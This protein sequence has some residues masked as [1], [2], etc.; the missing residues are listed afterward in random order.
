MSIRE[1]VKQFHINTKKK[2]EIVANFFKELPIFLW[3]QKGRKKHNNNFCPRDAR[4]FM[5]QLFHDKTYNNG[6]DRFP[7]KPCTAR[8]PRRLHRHDNFCLV[9]KTGRGVERS[10]SAASVMAAGRLP[11]TRDIGIDI[12]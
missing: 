12:N 11:S 7:F 10:N 1:D 9:P 5:K 2:I 3:H 6:T 8:A 4:D